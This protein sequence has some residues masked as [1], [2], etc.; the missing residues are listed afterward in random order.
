MSH[1][2]LLSTSFPSAI[3]VS[4]P[5][6]ASVLLAWIVMGVLSLQRRLNPSMPA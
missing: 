6:Q 5:R 3:A 2:L 4:C 1:H